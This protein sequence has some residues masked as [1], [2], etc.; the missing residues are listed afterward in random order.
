MQIDVGD[1]FS[2]IGAIATVLALFIAILIPVIRLYLNA[3]VNKLEKDLY[4]KIERRLDTFEER[5]VDKVS[6]VV[7]EILAD[8]GVAKDKEARIR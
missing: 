3:A 8:A 2:I 7:A 4:E 1:I 6:R 5:I